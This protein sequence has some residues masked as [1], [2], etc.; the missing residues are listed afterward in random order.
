MADYQKSISMQ[1]AEWVYVAPQTDALQCS[2]C[3]Y[4][5]LSIELV[6]PYCPWCGRRMTNTTTLIQKA[7]WEE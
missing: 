2:N 1:T 3:G 7:C 4:N 5:V 6:T